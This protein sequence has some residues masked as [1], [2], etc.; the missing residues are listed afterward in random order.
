MKT[1]TASSSTIVARIALQSQPRYLAVPALGTLVPFGTP[2]Q[3][4]AFA[5][6]IAF[7]LLLLFS[8]ASLA[9]NQ[10]RDAIKTVGRD[11]APSIIAAQRIRT[12]LADFDA[13]VVNQLICKPGS[14][15]MQ[16]A[17]KAANARH[18]E[19]AANLVHAAENITFGDAERT[20]ILQMTG[21]LGG[22]E[23]LMAKAI[24]LHADGDIKNSLVA[25]QEATALMH[26]SL[27]PAADALD[28]ANTAAMDRAFKAQQSSSF[29]LRSLLLAAGA[30]LVGALAAAQL[31]LIRRTH[32]LVNP[33]LAG[34]TL[35]ALLFLGYASYAVGNAEGLLKVAVKDAFASVH[36]LWQG[37]AIANDA[38]GEETR[39]LY[40]RPNAAK[41]QKNFFEKTGKIATVPASA[42][43]AEIANDA[44]A[45]RPLPKE[46]TGCLADELNNITFA[47]EREAA[48]NALSA[49]GVYL[50]VDKEIRAR[51]NEGDHAA[52]VK[53]CLSY[54]PGGSNWAFDQFEKALEEALAVNQKEFDASVDRGLAK[55]APFSVATPCA[56]LL[57][58]ALSVAG[59]WPRMKEY[60]V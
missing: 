10:S 50:G 25:G 4:W 12:A 46:F 45:S 36:V 13:N 48:T 53:L 32:R 16:L 60:E 30:L 11:C 23:A 42:T 59:F 27:L 15:D 54:E 28:A 3:L 58:A 5:G 17:V 52:A 56:A 24:T 29:L 49:Y 47:G 57:I 33:G 21:G 2:Q 40:D 34:A 39:W 35:V 22:Y 43:F 8:A 51:E 9:V 37:R 31:F 7:A 55:L 6:G 20:P 41:Y 14:T 26:D 44:L 1:Q 38:N 19:I 18:S